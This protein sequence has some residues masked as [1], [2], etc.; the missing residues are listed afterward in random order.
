MSSNW[1]HA[2][3]LVEDDRYRE[4]VRLFNDREWYAAHDAFEEL[5]HESVGEER[6]VFQGIIQIAVAEHHL[7]NGNRRGSLLLMAEGLNHLQSSLP[8]EL[9]FDLQALQ[10]IVSQRLAGLQTGQTMDDIPLPVLEP[11]APAKD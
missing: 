2:L 5:W 3:S 6:G 7:R 9:G 11:I 10:T 4:A 1:Q 8:Q